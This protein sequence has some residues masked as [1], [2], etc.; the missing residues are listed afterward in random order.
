MKWLQRIVVLGAG[1]QGSTFERS[2]M[3]KLYN[4][5]I[6]TSGDPR[7]LRLSAV[8]VKSAIAWPTDSLKV[9]AGQYSVWGFAW[10]GHGPIR[11][12]SLSLNGGKTWDLAK[13]EPQAS[14][15]GWARW[16]Y[17]WDAKS[18]DYAVMSRA[19]DMGGNEQPLAR[20]PA[21]KDGYELNWCLPVHCS[22]R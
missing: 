14:L 17:A 5:V 8:Q 1:D 4:R 9:P 20:D 3:T 2:G 21:R 12:L 11:K 18:G 22:V 19:A 7:T 16:T 15:H 13:V 6:G 10:S